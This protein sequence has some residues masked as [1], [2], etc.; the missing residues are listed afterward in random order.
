MPA[1]L[2]WFHIVEPTCTNN[3]EANIFSRYFFLHT[4]W[5]SNEPQI[6]VSITLS[7]VSCEWG[8]SHYV[9]YHGHH[10]IFSRVLLML[11]LTCDSQKFNTV[12]TPWHCV[13]KPSCQDN[14]P[15]LYLLVLLS[16]VWKD[17]FRVVFVI[18]PIPRHFT[19]FPAAVPPHRI[20]VMLLR[21]LQYNSKEFRKEKRHTII[22]SRPTL[23][24]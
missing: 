21:L 6:V 12:T 9:I 1:S 24:V 19:I 5:K 11:H 20:M 7:G 4:P 17:H 16:F 23:V 18:Q 14:N 22:S 8:T 10:L 3:C 15:Y 13:F 2:K